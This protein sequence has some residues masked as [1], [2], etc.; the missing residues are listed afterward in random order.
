MQSRKRVAEPH[1]SEDVL[2]TMAN[3]GMPEKLLENV[4]VVEL[5][6]R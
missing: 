6:M 2:E 4:A 1:P 5:R 3:A